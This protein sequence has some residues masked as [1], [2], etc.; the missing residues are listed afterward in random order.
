[1]MADSV[2]CPI[3]NSLTKQGDI[4]YLHVSK[5]LQLTT[6]LFFVITTIF[7]NILILVGAFS[8]ILD[9]GDRITAFYYM[10]FIVLMII[11]IFSCLLTILAFKQFFLIRNIPV[12]DNSI[13]FAKDAIKAIRILKNTRNWGEFYSLNI[14]LNKDGK[15][16]ELSLPIKPSTSKEEAEQ[17]AKEL[18][19]FFG[20]GIPIKFIK[21]KYSD[22]FNLIFSKKS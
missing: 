20:G 21:F 1:M 19:D 11:F 10:V 4:F 6:H 16:M 12:K 17:I 18:V 3:T 7:L 14:I 2:K 9:I 5:K 13:S 8:I 22:I 15:S